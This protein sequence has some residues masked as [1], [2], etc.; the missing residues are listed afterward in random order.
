MCIR[1]RNDTMSGVSGNDT[2]Y[3]G[4]DN[5]VLFGGGGNDVLFGGLGR[6]RLNGGAGED[7]FKFVS[8]DDS[9]TTTGVDVIAGFSGAG[10]QPFAVV[11]DGID[12]AAIDANTLVA[13]NQAF[14]FNGTTAGGVGRIWV[15]N[16]GT[17]TL[18]YINVDGDASAE[19]VVRIQDGASVAADY[20]AG[21]F[22]L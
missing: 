8:I 22:N 11:E 17:D 3:G 19:M 21:D 9:I 1:D 4:I 2:L 16:A 6:D 15:K 18:L 20:W 12:L 13:G 5:D 7:V 14:S 10:A